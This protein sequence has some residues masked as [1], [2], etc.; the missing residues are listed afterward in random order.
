VEV[1]NVTFT[2]DS[3]ID[4]ALTEANDLV[5]DAG[6]ASVF[7]NENIGAT[8]ATSELG[9]LEIEQADGGVTFGQAD[10]ETPLAGTTGPVNS[11][12]LVGDGTAGNALDIGSLST[13]QGTGITFNG[14]TV[15]AG[16]QLTIETTEDAVRINGAVTLATDV[17]IDT[18]VA[19]A[20]GVEVGNVTFTND[21]PI[22]SA[23]T[24]A[25]DLVLDAGTASVFF[26]EDIG[27]A[28]D[29]SELGRLEIEQADGGVTFG[30]ADAE[31][32]LAGTTG[33]VNSIELV[34]DGT[35]GNALDIGSLSTIGGTGIT[36][37][38]GTVGAGDKLTIETTED[39]VRINGAV[40]AATDVRIDTDVAAAS[41]SEVGDVTFTNDS[42]IDSALTEANDL[43]IDA[44]TASVF[45]NED[46]GAA[47]AT[48]ELGRL[49]IEQ[50]DGGVTFGEADT[51]TPLAGTT[52]PVNSIEL[53]GDGT[54]A[55][56]A[57]EVGSV[58]AI[59]GGIVLD[60]GPSND[61]WMLI[62]TNGSSIVFNGPVLLASGVEMDTG[63]GSITF[64]STLDGSA[65]SDEDLTMTVGTGD[66]DFHGAVG[67]TNNVGDIVINSA[68]DVTAH[69]VI[70]ALSFTQHDGSGE[71]GL[72]GDVTTSG[73]IAFRIETEEI[74]ITKITNLGSIVSLEATGVIKE[75]TTDEIE[76]GTGRIVEYRDDEIKTDTD[77]DILADKGSFVA[78][79]GIGVTDTGDEDTLEV[80]FN[81]LAARTTTGDINIENTNDGELTIGDV[82][83]AVG[84][85]EG[86]SI[87]A[88][89]DNDNIRI[90]TDGDL[91]VE[92]SVTTNAEGDIRIVAGGKIY[93]D[94][95]RDQNG[96]PIV[97]IETVSESVG[98]IP[99]GDDVII[100]LHDFGTGA[101]VQPGFPD[102]L[103]IFDVFMV[104][105]WG[106][107]FRVDIDW[108]LG[109]DRF[110]YQVSNDLPNRI[111]AWDG[112]E[113]AK[114]PVVGGVPY[115]VWHSY[116]TE[117][118]INRPSATDPLFVTITVSFG[119]GGGE[120][121]ETDDNGITL[122]ENSNQSGAGEA[123]NGGELVVATKMLELSVPAI[124]F[125]SIV[126]PEEA[127]EE[128]AAREQERPAV[129]LP[130]PAAAAEQ[131]VAAVLAA[132]VLNPAAHLELWRV[133]ATGDEIR[134]REPWP[135]GDTSALN[136]LPGLFSTLRNGHYRLYSFREGEDRELILDFYLE[137]GVLQ[138]APAEEQP[139]P[140]K[141]QQEPS[142]GVQAAD[143][144][145]DSQ[146]SDTSDGTA[147]FPSPS[148]VNVG[149]GQSVDAGAMGESDERL[150]T[151]EESIV[152]ALGAGLLLHPAQRLWE[153]RVDQA[154]KQAG[155]RS[156]NKISR[157][158]RRPRGTGRSDD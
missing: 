10:T 73:G 114:S 87:T 90:V 74:R 141:A 126:Q 111:V 125:A 138:E 51:E 27:A 9:R 40:T 122:I 75:G 140:A 79:S 28:A 127:I 42:P 16:D 15:G 44:G 23:L 123:E 60:G 71:T 57:L 146:Q 131:E 95:A 121:G 156:Q 101:N 4:S 38:G 22:D 21:S 143:E 142:T 56:N 6:T 53:V 26:N 2:N 39:A 96:D 148:G 136:D 65:N 113:E 89:G 147:R 84:T 80:S 7:F 54:P 32:P 1:G 124:G 117:E 58:E 107:N 72:R 135:T 45:F 86:V 46:I 155:R 33:P 112:N 130:T 61:V 35:A 68:K 82:T 144:A 36:F 120:P 109:E 24:E 97:I 47:A 5:L 25:N 18:D 78:G 132:A 116:I 92:S 118:I 12:E 128:I 145:P 31:T 115:V 100:V 55:V 129:P 104:D 34:G 154:L 69:F 153:Q 157:M 70:E 59:T 158:C 19:G 62:E 152:A 108:G 83:T 48:S 13:I 66:V 50:A 29:T 103:A 106:G 43:V 85:T 37:N 151:A 102:T 64:T 91:R 20:S 17:R 88:G 63:G 3:P 41:G 119:F 30:E 14:G 76:E 81:T 99:T 8:A 137:G 150:P 67:A 77:V 49:E 149:R 110:V 105:V 98:E 52:G 93:V 94:E 11:I 139:R 133:T 134:A